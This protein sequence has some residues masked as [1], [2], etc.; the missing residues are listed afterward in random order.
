MFTNAEV[1]AHDTTKLLPPQ[2]KQLEIGE[3]IEALFK[4]PQGKTQPPNTSLTFL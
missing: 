1:T 3:Q 2:E 4:E